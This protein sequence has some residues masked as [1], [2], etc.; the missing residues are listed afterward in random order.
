MRRG[1]S[2]VF[3]ELSL[4]PSLS[5]AENIFANRQPVRRLG[6]IDVP[7]LHR[8]AR[9]LLALFDLQGL[10]PATPGAG[11]RPGHAAGGRDPEGPLHR[12]RRS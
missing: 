10:D 11:A 5:V 8:R 3:Q 12:A 2:I 7:E 4:V 9:E 1:I 6:Y